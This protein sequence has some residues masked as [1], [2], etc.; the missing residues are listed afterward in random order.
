MTQDTATTHTV[1]PL[2]LRL[3]EV[4]ALVD[5]LLDEPLGDLDSGP[6]LAAARR[7][8]E[9]QRVDA[10]EVVALGLA[11]HAQLLEAAAVADDGRREVLGDVDH[12]LAL[13]DG[14]DGSSLL[15]GATRAHGLHDATLEVVSIRRA[16]VRLEAVLGS[17][18]GRA[19]FAPLDVRVGREE[20][21]DRAIVDLLLGLEVGLDVQ[22]TLELAFL[23]LVRE[24]VQ[25]VADLRLERTPF[26]DVVR[27]VREAP[28]A[29]LD[30][31]AATLALGDG[32]A[33]LL[34]VELVLDVTL[35]LSVVAVAPGTGSGAAAN[36]ARV[37]WL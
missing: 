22:A 1:K 16:L 17:L 13:H 8:P 14:L 6:S 3:T 12:V 36:A 4:V 5:A 15:G 33:L 11:Q 10:L 29:A 31:L 30:A 23:L 28:E 37:A 19:P 9:A 7:S 34:L 2:A 35:G 26:V 20:A 24:V 25:R 18:L 21:G 27:I 32:L